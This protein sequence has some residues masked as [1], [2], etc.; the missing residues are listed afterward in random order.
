MAEKKTTKKTTKQTTEK[1]NTDEVIKSLIGMV[2][3]LQDQVAA[4]NNTVIGVAIE[5]KVKPNRILRYSPTKYKDFLHN[6]IRPVGLMA[7]V[8]SAR[9]YDLE[10]PKEA[11]KEGGDNED[12]SEE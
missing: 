9:L 12:S 4:L 7:E 11:D 1:P 8:L 3:L 5:A 6:N 2:N 10:H